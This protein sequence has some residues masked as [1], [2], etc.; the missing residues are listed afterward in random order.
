[1]VKTR[2]LQVRLT[3][4][5]HERLKATSRLRGFS[6]LASYLRYVG[7]Q[8]DFTVHDKVVEMHRFLLGGPPRKAR[9]RRRPEG[10]APHDT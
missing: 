9:D 7:L 8:Q 10:D 2:A 4:E 6:S 5:Q 3:P 1:M